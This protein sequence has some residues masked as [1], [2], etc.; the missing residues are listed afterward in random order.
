LRQP[1]LVGS[2]R[3]KGG[4]QCRLII[5]ARYQAPAMQRHRHQHIRLG[6]KRTTCPRHHAGENA[7]Q[8]RAVAM[9]QG[10]NEAPRRIVIAE[11]GPRPGEAG[12][13]QHTGQA[14]ARR[15]R[16]GQWW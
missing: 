3:E 8:F 16:F 15:T 12:R 14:M 2:A 11:R 5:A 4:E 10:K 13:S 6:Q 7:R 9:L 1:R